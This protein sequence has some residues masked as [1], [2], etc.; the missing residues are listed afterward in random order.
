MNESSVNTAMTELRQRQ[1]RL[2]TR[3]EEPD[4]FDRVC[5]LAHLVNNWRTAIVLTAEL[6]RL[7]V[8]PAELPVAT[9]APFRRS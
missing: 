6:E 3:A 1:G 2:G 7:G 8:N 4:D 9:D 5:S